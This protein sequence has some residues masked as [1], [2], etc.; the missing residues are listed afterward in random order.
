[1][2]DDENTMQRALYQLYKITNSCNLEISTENTKLMAFMGKQPMRS[3]LLLENQI[4]G[5]VR[6][7]DFLGCYISYL[8][9]DI[10][11]KIGR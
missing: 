11:N 9:V 7:F 6:K 5:Q 8:E 10:N 1:M 2:A 4:I 3:K